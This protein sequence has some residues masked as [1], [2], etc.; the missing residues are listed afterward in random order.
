MGV[1]FDVSRRHFLKAGAAAG[2]GLAIALYLPTAAG[3]A[4]EADTAFA[5]NAWLVIEPSG[6]VVIRVASSEMGQGVMT[7]MPM[8]VA[9]E[10]DADW[11]RVRVETAPEGKPYYNP[12]LGS[13]STGGSTAVRGFWNTVREAGAVAREMLVVAA[14][15]RWQVDASQCRTGKGAVAHPGSGR[16][17]GYGELAEAAARLP[18]PAAAFLKDPADFTLVGTSVPRVDTPSKV[19][20]TA[21]FG[22]DVR[23]PGM[24]VAVV[25]RSPAF[26]GRARSF[27]A[28]GARSVRGVRHV[29]PLEHGVAV[30]ADG[31]WPAAKGRDALRAQWDAG[32]D[33]G[34]DSAAIAKR[35]AAAVKNGVEARREGDVDTAF[36][37][38]ARRIEAVYDV[39]YLAHACMEPMNCTA[40][41]RADG[42]DVWAP[43]QSQT[44]T[45]KKAAEITG[46]PIDQVTVHTTFLGGGF[47]RRSEVDFVAEAVTLS[48]TVGAPVKVVWTREDD[49]HHDFYRPATH[50]RLRAGLDADG[51]LVAWEHRIASPS[52]L[53]RRFPDAVKNGIDRTS[54]EGAANLPYSVPNLLVTCARVDAGVPVGFW[55]SVGSSQNAFVTECFLDEVARAAGVDP[56]EMR[57]R[58]LADE[59][60]HLGVLN[61][62]ADRAGWSL[63]TP[64][65]RHRGIA[66]A[67]SFGSFVAQVAEVS[68]EQGEVRVHRVVCAI[69]CGLT[70]NPDTIEAQME[71]GIVYG[72][73]AALY[74]E[75][76]IRD[77]GVVQ[78]N[79]DDY[80]LLR[81]KDMPRVEVHIVQSGEHPGG[82]GEPGTPPIAPAV[83]NAVAAATGKPVRSLPIRLG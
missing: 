1:R 59:P 60:R 55:R 81:L 13:Q 75:I 49:M 9:E 53:A 22:L 32:P 82:V 48:K 64:A 70:V 44:S 37:A 72:L 47:G 7:A 52:I 29:V 54:V 16:Q 73:T 76:T 51:R 12:L 77:G 35:F 36:D 56:L 27:D 5:P 66:V 45:R 4:A 38:A 78:G 11:S 61:L 28:D 18:V 65:G 24:L 25:A 68:L 6:D 62:A 63:P 2:G 14:A 83:A 23:M 31:F 19:D 30:I 26:G 42:C 46:L 69:D 74:G 39:P 80:P 21:Q 41:V 43:T 34:L 71:S 20:G 50:N 79:F 8:L 15:Q 3:R 17:A 33:S 57:R 40:H 58:L 10:L 67:E